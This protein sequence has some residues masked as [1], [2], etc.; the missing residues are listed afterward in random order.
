MTRMNILV[1]VLCL[2]MGRPYQFY[3]FVPLVSFWFVVIYAVIAVWPRVTAALV[4]GE[5][6]CLLSSRPLASCFIIFSDSSWPALVDV[7]T[8]L[9]FFAAVTEVVTQEEKRCVTT[10]ITEP[11]KETAILDCDILREKNVGLQGSANPENINID[12]WRNSSKALAP[13]SLSS[14]EWKILFSRE[15]EDEIT[16][17]FP[18]SFFYDFLQKTTCITL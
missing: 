7:N 1:A 18:E 9:V 11:A 8:D 17:Y 6:L 15:F 10:L 16:V 4:K 12:G 14:T 3:Y 5:M 2:I 13:S